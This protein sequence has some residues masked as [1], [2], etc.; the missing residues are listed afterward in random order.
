MVACYPN[1]AGFRCERSD[2]CAQFGGTVNGGLGGAG[3]RWGVTIFAKLT[4]VEVVAYEDD[5]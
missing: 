1:D 4:Q 5:L 3:E 2:L